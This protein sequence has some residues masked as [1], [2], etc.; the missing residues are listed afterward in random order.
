MMIYQLFTSVLLTQLPLLVVYIV[1]LV[2]A[3]LR[4]R[5]FATVSTLV[6][7]AMVTFILASLVNI[8]A[9]LVPALWRTDLPTPPI[10][11]AFGVIS[12]IAAILSA[13]GWVFLVAAVFIDR[14][15]P[16]ASSPPLPSAEPEP[17]SH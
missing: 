13:A 7:V 12:F 8:F 10:G 2:L 3:V 4:R 14:K 5:Q 11:T 6:I 15:D 9:S 16:A 1:V 17:P